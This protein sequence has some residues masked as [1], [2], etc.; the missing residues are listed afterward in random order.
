VGALFV[1]LFNFVIPFIGKLKKKKTFDPHGFG[2]RTSASITF[3]LP[4]ALSLFLPLMFDTQKSER[5]ESTKLLIYTTLQSVESPKVVSSFCLCCWGGRGAKG[6]V[7]TLFNYLEGFF[8]S[9]S[10]SSL[11]PFWKKIDSTRTTYASRAFVQKFLS[12][13]NYMTGW[14]LNET[15]H[16]Q[17]KQM[18]TKMVL[19]SNNNICISFSKNFKNQNFQLNF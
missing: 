9:F 8:S 11:A 17:T 12:F 2:S 14:T 10:S 18:K 1:P 15:F 3:R 16:K 19:S 6:G 4:R 13:K 7:G 5:T